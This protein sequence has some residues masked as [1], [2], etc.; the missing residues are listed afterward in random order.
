MVLSRIAPA[1]ISRGMSVRK[2]PRASYDEIEGVCN[3]YL[4]KVCAQRERAPPLASPP[5]TP[6]PLHTQTGG[7]YD[8]PASRAV[9]DLAHEVKALLAPAQEEDL[10]TM[11]RI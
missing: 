4:A 7:A 3:H 9:F 1:P 5:L 8:G 11:M 2:L 6:R 10:T